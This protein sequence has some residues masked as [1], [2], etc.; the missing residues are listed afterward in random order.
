MELKELDG[1][2]AL[3][4]SVEFERLPHPEATYNLGV[5]GS[6][7]YFAETAACTV[8]APNTDP[9]SILFSRDPA[10][11]QA[12]DTFLHGDWADGRTLGDAVR[13]ART[14]GQLPEGLT[15]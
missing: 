14:L 3:V 12:S 8:L 5:E 15:L 6:H 1:S 4:S 2:L 10:G 13:E 7:N 11:I 9:M